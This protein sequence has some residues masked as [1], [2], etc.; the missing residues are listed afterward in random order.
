MDFQIFVDII[1]SISIIIASV[2]AIMGVSSWR[3]EAKWRRKY[4]LAE[5][6][7][8]NAYDA[9][10]RFRIIR[11]SISH[12]EEGRTRQID[13]SENPKHAHVI[14]LGYIIYERFNNEKEPFLQLE[15]LV[16]RFMAL[17]GKEEAKPLQEIINIKNEILNNADLF[18]KYSI[19]RNDEIKNGTSDNEQ[20]TFY[21]NCIA[22]AKTV[23]WELRNQDDSINIR[24]NKAI[25]EL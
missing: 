12:P 2:I 4:E 7:L 8:A 20:I 5:D 18:V 17:V 21:S 9:Q 15:K 13:P 16:F 19:W 23:I 25:K 24:I 22:E 11:H 1:S 3:H 6:V 10:I 14:R